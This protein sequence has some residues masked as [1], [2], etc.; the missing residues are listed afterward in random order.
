MRS[1]TLID[2][3]FI[4]TRIKHETPLEGFGLTENTESKQQISFVCVTTSPLCIFNI[5][6]VHLDI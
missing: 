3:I 1:D 4:A 6:T 5:K 2:L